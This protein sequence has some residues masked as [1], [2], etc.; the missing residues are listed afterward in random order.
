MSRVLVI[1]IDALDSLLLAKFGDDLTDA[2]RK[3]GGY[4][5]LGLAHMGKAE[6]PQAK[7]YFEKAVSLD[8]GQLWARIYLEDL[9]K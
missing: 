3:A 4:Y 5:L 8:I 2:Q 6:I 1:G 7:E 9:N